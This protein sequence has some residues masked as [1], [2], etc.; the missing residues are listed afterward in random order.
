[1]DRDIYSGHFPPPWGGGKIFQKMKNR[2]EFEGGL[3]KSPQKQGRIFIGG[4]EKFCWLARIYTPVQRAIF[5][6]INVG[7]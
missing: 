5:N 2:E 4:W 6:I 1:M 3:N 7:T